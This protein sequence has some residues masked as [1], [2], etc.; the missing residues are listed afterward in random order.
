LVH[1][2]K[3]TGLRIDHID[4]LYNPT[5]YLERLQERMPDTYITVEK[6]LQPG[7]T[8]PS[9]WSIQGTS[10]YD[11]LIYLNSLFCRTQNEDKFDHIY[12]DVTGMR[13][14]FHDIVAEKKHLIIDKNLAGD[15]DNLAVL[16]K[17]ISRKYRYGNDFTVNGLKRAIAEV[18]TRFPIYRTYTT[19]DSVLEG[20]R[21]YFEKFSNRQR[22]HSIAVP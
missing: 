20:D 5:Q 12:S 13:Q 16:L 11:Y 21:P 19:Q 15:V 7:E 6:I 8:L 18:L 9:N 4:G 17:K 2:G 3:F 10:G 22:Q 1:A 14:P